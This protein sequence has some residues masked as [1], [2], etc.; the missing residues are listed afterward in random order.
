[1]H[2]RV[3]KGL[4]IPIEGAPTDETIRELSS[5][6]VALDVSDYRYLRFTLLKKVG[7]SVSQGEPILEDKAFP[8]R[9]FVATVSGTIR[10]VV[11]GERRQIQEIVIE[12]QGASKHDIV[13]EE[14]KIKWLALNGLFHYIRCRPGAQ[15]PRPGQTPNCIFV[16]ATAT[17]P[18]EPSPNMEAQQHLDDFQ[19]GLLFLKEIC[20]VHLVGTE[21]SFEGIETHTVEGKHPAGNASVHIYNINPLLKRDQKIWTLG[22]SGVIAIGKALHGEYYNSRVI[23]VAGSPFPTE[24]R[25][26]YNSDIG[27]SVA[28]LTE[29]RP[30]NTRIISGSPLTGRKIKRDGF[31]GFNDHVISALDEEGVSDWMHFCRLGAKRFTT[32]RTYLSALLK[33]CQLRTTAQYGEERPFVDADI[34]ER[35]MPMQIPVMELVKA[36]MT[37]NFELAEELGLLEVA[38]EDFALPAF[39][40]PSKIPMMQII[41]DG[42]DDY[43]EQYLSD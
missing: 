31:L 43:V 26:Y 34:Y 33:K 36:V 29:R 8:E 20:P 2:I 7:E 27:V 35:V 15:L 24:V 9:R 23:A 13:E 39:V 5:D 19:K 21:G 41:R 1:M 16:N 12:K 30:E 38:P 3:K 14:D 37:K 11:R 4:D 42:L 28:S 10:D 6:N 32:T 18:F 25:G 40:C 22:V 17:A